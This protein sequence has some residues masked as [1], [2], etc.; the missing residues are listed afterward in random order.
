MIAKPLM[1]T[2]RLE[3]MNLMISTLGC[4]NICNHFFIFLYKKKIKL[5]N[6]YIFIFKIDMPP[7]KNKI[8][9]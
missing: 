9:N 1:T 2:K 7:S 6:F 5:L 3:F 4:L 8:T